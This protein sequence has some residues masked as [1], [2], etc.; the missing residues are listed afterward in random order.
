MIVANIS[1]VNRP[2]RDSNEVCDF[3]FMLLSISIFNHVLNKHKMLRATTET[4]H[5]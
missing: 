5:V 2:E 3:V 1:T 4:Y